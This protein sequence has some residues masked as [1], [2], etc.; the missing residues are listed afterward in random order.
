MLIKA[1]AGSLGL[2][3]SSGWINNDLFP[4][5]LQHFIKRMHISSDN[6]AL[7]LLDNNAY[8]ISIKAIAMSRE[9]NLIMLLL[10]SHCSHKLQPLDVCVIA[11]FKKYNNSV[12]D[13][14]MLENLKKMYLFMMYHPFHTKLARKHSGVK[15]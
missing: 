13:G 9:D 6:Q 4:E 8:H 10:R 2:A 12:C 7:L 11:A 1:P 3:C 5:I 14:W 15:V